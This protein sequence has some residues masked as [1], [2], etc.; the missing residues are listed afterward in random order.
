MQGRTANQLPPLKD[1]AG[2][3]SLLMGQGNKVV[4][5]PY[6]DFVGRVQSTV[7]LEPLIAALQP[8]LQEARDA[9]DR[10]ADSAAEAVRQGNVPIYSTAGGL[11]ALSIPTDIHILRVNGQATSDDGE[12][13]DFV[14]APNGSQQ[15]VP[16]DDGRTWYKTQ[17]NRRRYVDVGTFCALNDTVNADAGIA[18]AIAGGMGRE[19]V[20]TNP[21]GGTRNYKL[22]AGLAF[23]VGNV[24]LICNEGATIDISALVGDTTSAAPGLDFSGTLAASVNLS[25]DIASGATSLSLISA[26]GLLANDWLFLEDNRSWWTTS[27]YGEW[28]KIKSIVG[29]TITLWAGTRYAYTTANVARVSKGNLLYGVKARGLRFRG[30]GDGTRTQTGIRLRRTFGALIEDI[31][32]QGCDYLGSVFDNTLFCEVRGA[33]YRNAT[34]PGLAYGHGITKG[35]LGTKVSGAYGDDLRHVVTVGGAGGV[36]IDTTVLDVSGRNMIDATVDAH[37]QVDGCKFSK[38]FHHAAAAST[39]DGVV[40]QG[41]NG[42]IEDV[43]LLNRVPRHGVNYQPSANERGSMSIKG[44][45]GSSAVNLVSC[46]IAFDMQGLDI[47]TVIGHATARMVHLSASAGGKVRRFGI[48]S[49]ISTSEL[50]ARSIHLQTVTA[51]TE[52]SNGSISGCHSEVAVGGSG[53]ME[54]IY[55]QGATALAITEVSLAG[56]TTKGGNYGLR[57]LN[58]EYI[59]TAANSFRGATNTNRSVAG[60]SNQLGT[61]ITA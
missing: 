14:D 50:P 57:G 22:S 21:T 16:S 46:S 19:I 30:L 18:A 23:A 60:A 28:V 49:V 34:Y 36:C 9:A 51:G 42:E 58:T 45:Y 54:S 8:T 25:A 48:K 24:E 29:T 11:A 59:T 37:P 40:Y 26:V 53:G 43:R 5:H 20:F 61:D 35:C 2:T 3:D 27:T 55:L 32:T 41:A 15:T 13:G 7:V 4:R 47:D 12:G 17:I 38:I 56:N 39:L 10:A 44:I 6:S 33:N 52:I 1:P 31:D